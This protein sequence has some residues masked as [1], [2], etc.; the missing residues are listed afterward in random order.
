MIT[1]YFEG[2]LSI[3]LCGFSVLGF[4]GLLLFFCLGFFY[5]FFFLTL[6][7]SEVDI[8]LQ[9]HVVLLCLKYLFSEMDFI[10]TQDIFLSL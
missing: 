6:L 9:K 8:I 4:F 2:E 5:G 7:N 3:M 10:A 1:I